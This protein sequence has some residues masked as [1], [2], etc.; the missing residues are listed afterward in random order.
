M[1]NRFL[2]IMENDK[3]LEKSVK[4]IFKRHIT[5]GF[6]WSSHA[7]L[8]IPLFKNSYISIAVEIMVHVIIKTFIHKLRQN[9]KCISIFPFFL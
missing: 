4:K 2:F 3:Q 7:I 9:F 6:H 8:K 5:D 1:V